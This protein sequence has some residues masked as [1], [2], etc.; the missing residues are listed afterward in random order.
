MNDSTT[1]FEFA[2]Q[3][4]IENIIKIMR[5]GYYKIEILYYVY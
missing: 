1:D 3:D 4:D 5:N 2:N